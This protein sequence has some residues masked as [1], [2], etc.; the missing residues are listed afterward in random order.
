MALC[1]LFSRPISG[2]SMNPARSISAALVGGC[3]GEQWI[4]LVGPV[5][6][7]CLAVVAMSGVHP[8]RHSGEKDAAAG[9]TKTEAG[10]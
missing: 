10:K 5:V 9:E 3:L 2:A 1:S 4:Y 8:R 6:G 7:A